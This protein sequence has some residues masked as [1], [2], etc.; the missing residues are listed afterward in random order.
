[1]PMSNQSPNTASRIPLTGLLS[2]A[3]PM[4]QK[5]PKEGLLEAWHSLP[6]TSLRMMDGGKTD[7]I[8]ASQKGIMRP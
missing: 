7:I 8:I 5:E 2:W 6:L 4:V 1:M 3:Q